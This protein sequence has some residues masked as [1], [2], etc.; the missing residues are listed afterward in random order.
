MKEAFVFTAFCSFCFVLV[1]ANPLT[2]DP[3]LSCT[4]DTS[5]DKSDYDVTDLKISF[6]PN[7]PQKGRNLTIIASGTVNRQIAGGKIKVT[8][9]Y[10]F[11]TVLNQSYDV[12]DFA[13]K[14]G[15]ECP[16]PAG[17]LSGSK[18]V[19]V[20]DKIPGGTYLVSIEGT[21]Q[22]G[23]NMICANIKCNA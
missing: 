6:S 4:V 8:A 9:K 2:K 5:C 7:P 10:G 12:C 18:T 19:M 15:K 20:P 16:I 13:K 21:D 3:D 11:I 23:K 22:G 1:I 14:M 17:P